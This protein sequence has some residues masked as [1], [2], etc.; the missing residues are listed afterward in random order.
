M[1]RNLS[2]NYE[3]RELE[4][5]DDGITCELTS[6]KFKSNDDAEIAIGGKLLQELKKINPENFECAVFHIIDLQSTPRLYNPLLESFGQ[7]M[8]R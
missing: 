3:A 7:E 8:L 6:I 1:L 5:F 4:R 2:Y